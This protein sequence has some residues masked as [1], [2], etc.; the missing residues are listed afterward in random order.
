MH[1]LLGLGFYAHASSRAYAYAGSFVRFLLDRYGAARLR[2]LYRSGGAFEAVYR[3]PLSTLQAQ[4]HAVIDELALSAAERRSAEQT[5]R[6][7]SIFARPCPHTV[8]R[9]RQRVDQAQQRRD[10]AAAIE[11]LERLCRADPGTPWYR[12]QLADALL[13]N[14]DEAASL[15][16]IAPL[17]TNSQD[18]AVASAVDSWLADHHWRH[19]RLQA[20][21]AALDAAAQRAADVGSARLIWLKRWALDQPREV[22]KIVFDY[23]DVGRDR[24]RFARIAALHQAYRLTDVLPQAAIGWYLV[25]KQLAAARLFEDARQPLQHALEL[26]LSDPRFTV[27]AYR[28]LGRSAFRANDFELAARSFSLLRTHDKPQVSLDAEDWLQRIHWTQATRHRDEH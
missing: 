21:R 3:V 20:A 22:R 14:G 13:N 8:A 6:R 25:G 28:T 9:L 17:R 19:N 26:G 11:T 1:S 27:E 5:F 24:P 7:P 15:S 2:A 12:L 18:A 4:W 23:L 16:T 10:L